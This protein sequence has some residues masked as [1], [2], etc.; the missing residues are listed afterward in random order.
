M[1]ISPFRH[2]V[3]TKYIHLLRRQCHGCGNCVE[4]CPEDVFRAL[5]RAHRRHVRL[6]NPD[7]CTGCKKCVRA[8]EYDAIEYTYIPKSSRLSQLHLPGNKQ[9]KIERKLP[10]H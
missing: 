1:N 9:L 5:H 6:K 2:L 3:E 8:C 7:A 4:V 10:V